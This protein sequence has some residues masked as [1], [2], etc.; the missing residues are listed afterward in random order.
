MT[1][2]LTL[3]HA[4]APITKT[5]PGPPAEEERGLWRLAPEQVAAFE[6]DGFLDERPLLDAGQVDA[7]RGA[8]EEVG[9]DLEA[10]AP[11]LYEVEA[12]WLQRP[13]EVVLHFLGGW[14]VDERLH[15]LLFHP[16]ITVPAAQLLGVDRLRFWHDQVFWKP[17]GHPGVVPW[18]Q[19]YS[20]WTRTAP[21]RHV[22]AFVALDD[23]TA[24]NGGLQYVPGSHRWPLAPAVAFGGARDALLEHLGPSE[25][26]AFRPRG[27]RIAAG[28]VGFHHSHLVHGS[29]GN[30]TNGPR[31][32]IVLNFMAPDTRAVVG[33]EPLLSGTP[34]FEEG[35]VVDGP[36]HPLV[37]G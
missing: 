27:A 19:D 35:A 23:M 2:R 15:D 17:A 13:D 12:D 37:L 32:A 25:R 22:T 6:R 7:L 18:H 31:R 20:Y 30:E 5:F 26:A 34:A 11:D 28:Q 4:H 24:A 14:R 36:F 8:L 1:P 10:L 9:R 33:G 16:G 3:E 21:A 29:G